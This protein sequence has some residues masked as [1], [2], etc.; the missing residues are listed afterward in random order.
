MI[1]SVT[2][3]LQ[4]LEGKVDFAI[5]NK[6]EILNFLSL[7]CSF[8]TYSVSL[9]Q[10][11]NLIYKLTLSCYLQV[12]ILKH[13]CK[14]LYWFVTVCVFQLPSAVSWHRP[15]D[16]LRFGYSGTKIQQIY[17]PGRGN[18]AIARVG[19][20]GRP[21]RAQ[22]CEGRKNRKW[23]LFSICFWI[24]L[25]KLVRLFPFFRGGGG[26]SDLIDI[27]KWNSINCP[28]LTA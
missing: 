17:T 12:T 2:L 3:Q 23:K 21:P 22:L 15:L 20:E 10:Y 13:K 14:R 26:H 25:Q 27:K 11:Y 28:A 7:P 18:R 16:P 6:F 9:E 8:G 1:C 19:R 24:K 5:L 4:H